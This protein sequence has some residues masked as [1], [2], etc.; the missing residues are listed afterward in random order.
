M[1]R[2][3]KT[4]REAGEAAVIPLPWTKP[5]LTGNR[6]RGNPYARAAEVKQA[7]AEARWAIRAT[8]PWPVL[9]AEV[10]LHFRPRD[11][12]RRDADGLFPTLKVCQDALVLEGVIGDDSW[13]TIP[14]ATCRI[15][16]PDGEPATWL[17]LAAVTYAEE[18]RP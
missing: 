5:P 1:T 9:T 8:K 11:R 15:H 4:A 13:A 10:V 3:R 6:T 18:P 14:A 7:L 16:P 17:E 2:S 12:R